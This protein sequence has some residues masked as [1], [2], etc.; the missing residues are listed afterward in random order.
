MV[1]RSIL[2]VLFFGLAVWIVAWALAARA[3]VC[4]RLATL[5]GGGGEGRLFGRNHDG[6]S[7]CSVGMF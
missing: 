6:G 4:G 7:N 1:E 2:L 3:F 5:K